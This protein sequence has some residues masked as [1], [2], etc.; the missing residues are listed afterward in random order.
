M[1]DAATATRLT[2]IIDRLKFY[3][4]CLLVVWLPATV[5]RAVEAALGGRALFGLVLFA[6]VFSSSQGLC[7]AAAY[8]LSR[9]GR[10][11]L[12]A[13]AFSG[14]RPQPTQPPQQKRRAQ[15]GCS[16]RR[17]KANHQSRGW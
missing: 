10:E 6:R 9:N 3:P 11:A 13:D 7:N 1:T 12:H 2:L 8:G 14:A 16:T 5:S 4:F 15:S 17:S